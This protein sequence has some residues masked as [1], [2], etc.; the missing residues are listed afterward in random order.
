MYAPGRGSG[1]QLAWM[2]RF[3]RQSASAD[4]RH[5][6]RPA[7]DG[8][9]LH[10]SIIGPGAR[11]LR[12]RRLLGARVPTRRFG[13]FDRPKQRDPSCRFFREYGPLQ[14]GIEPGIAPERIGLNR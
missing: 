11:P 6:E 7:V 14:G 13:G 9:N 5:P 4:G 2:W 1:T 12:G 3:G 8:H 10:Q